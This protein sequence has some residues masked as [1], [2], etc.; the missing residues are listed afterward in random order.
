MRRRLRTV[1]KAKDRNSMCYWAKVRNPFRV[2][3]NYVVVALCRILPSLA[4]KR[5]LL[6]RIGVKVGK[7]VAFGLESTV[8]VFYPEL[9]EIGDD[10]II[11]Y[12]TVILAHEFLGDELR[13]GEVKIGR[14]VTI[15]ANCTILPGVRIGDN[16]VISAHSL[17]NSD[18]PPNVLAGGVPAKVIKV[19]YFTDGNVIEGDVEEDSGEV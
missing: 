15:G 14:R 18:I 11:G 13:I 16:A 1:I 4:L 8:D 7:N 3:L 10:T 6:R 12:N 19:N 5:F 17:V 9:I 2:A